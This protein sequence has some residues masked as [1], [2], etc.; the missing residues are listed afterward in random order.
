M[1]KNQKPKTNNQKPK[2]NNQKPETKNYFIHESSYIDDDV[3][4]GDN[5]KIWHFLKKAPDLSTCPRF[6]TIPNLL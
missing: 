3:V 4:I 5:T 2:T 6:R 1:T